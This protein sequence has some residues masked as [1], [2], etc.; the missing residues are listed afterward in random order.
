ME[1]LSLDS[2][3][4]VK[5]FSQE[6]DTEKALRIRDAFVRG[7]VELFISSLAFYEVTNAL[8][9]K[10]DFDEHKLKRAVDS[11]FMLH[12]NVVEVNSDLL[13]RSAEIAYDGNVTIY[14]AVPVAI[15]ELI[16][17][18]CVTADEKTQ[19]NRLKDKYPIVLLRDFEL[20]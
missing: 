12:L 11:L 5:W 18:V 9:Y 7:D 8:R 19:Y 17:G 3:V 14:D 13:K 16:D 1:K 10:P 4:I 20:K 6:E 15:A 2:S